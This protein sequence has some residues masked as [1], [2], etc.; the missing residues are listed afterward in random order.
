MR[1]TKHEETLPFKYKKEYSQSTGSNSTHKEIIYSEYNMV[2]NP[3]RQQEA[4]QLAIYKRG[5]GAEL[6][7]T[8]KQLQ[9]AVRAELEQGPPDFLRFRELSS[10]SDTF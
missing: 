10:N 8:K 9:L 4:D 1:L 7:A 2:K 5:R 3:S 6:G